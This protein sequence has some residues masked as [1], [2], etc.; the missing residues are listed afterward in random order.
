VRD[1]PTGVR[2]V[3]VDVFEHPGT[4]IGQIA[5][6]TGFP[7]SHVSSAVARLRTA[8]VLITEADPRDRRRTLVAP[9]PD[10][11]HLAA[12]TRRDLRRVEDLVE[13]SLVDRLG[14]DGADY[15][16][17]VIA[18]LEMLA[19]LF[20]RPGPDNRGDPAETTEATDPD[21]GLA[22]LQGDR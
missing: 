8:E 4:T 6:R 11:R 21:Q 14:P 5:A 1:L 9:S 10:H 22:I 2:L 15:V 13:V 20:V 19:D 16:G 7:Q 18:S 3:L 12:R 17:P